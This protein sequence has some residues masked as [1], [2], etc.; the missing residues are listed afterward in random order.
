M[1]KS[2]AVGFRSA[3]IMI[4]ENDLTNFFRNKF[5]ASLRQASN[6][7]ISHN[8]LMSSELINIILNVSKF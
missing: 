8:A 3:S 2:V 5:Q 6:G 4:M 7:Y 1:S